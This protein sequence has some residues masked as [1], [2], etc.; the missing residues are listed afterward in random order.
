MSRY[1][2]VVEEFA[3]W[4][5]HARFHLSSDEDAPR[6]FLPTVKTPKRYRQ[7]DYGSP[8]WYTLE[9]FEKLLFANV[10]ALEDQG[11]RETT[12]EFAK[13]FKG[14]SSNRKAFT[15]ALR[16]GL[17]KYL[18]DIRSQETSER[19][20]HAL[21]AAVSPPSA[22]TLGEVGEAHLKTFMQQWDVIE[23]LFKYKKVAGFLDGTHIPCVLEVA[24][25][26]TQKL[27][28]RRVAFGL[29]GTVTYRSPFEEDLYQPT[30]VSERDAPWQ[31]VKGLRELLGAYRIAPQ[32]PVM[33][34]VHL[35]CPNI[36]Y[37]D[38]GKSTFH[39][40]SVKPAAFAAGSDLT[41]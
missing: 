12:L 27:R 33:V 29:N 26:A 36:R 25:G 37:G 24:I 8:H 3:L 5:P 30:K 20:F 22:S 18:T 14:C 38:Y 2:R 32:D 35:L 41:H 1:G 7:D 15:E 23:T 16:E 39:T 4:N 40:G 34:A 11:A 31:K 17:P 10:R 13:R 19:L 9:D 6:V 21:L 28:E